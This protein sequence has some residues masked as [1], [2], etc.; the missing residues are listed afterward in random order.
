MASL[1]LISNK[2]AGPKDTSYLLKQAG[3]NLYTLLQLDSWEEQE[4]VKKYQLR[5]VLIMPNV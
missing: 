3:E 5:S 4:N 1:K 2:T